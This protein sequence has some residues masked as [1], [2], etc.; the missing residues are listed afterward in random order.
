[1]LDIMESEVEAAINSLKKGKAPGEDNIAAEMIQARGG[2]SLEM[3]HG[4]CNQIYNQKEYPE[5]RDRVI[6]PQ[7]SPLEISARLFHSKLKTLLFSK[8]YPD[9]SSSSYLPPRLNSKHHPP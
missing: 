8:S 9:L 2:C 7:T 3:L 4:L 6:K 1:M 5:D